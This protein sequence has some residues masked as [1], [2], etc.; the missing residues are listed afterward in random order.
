MSGWR[1]SPCSERGRRGAG[2]PGLTFTDQEVKGQEEQHSDE[3]A[4]EALAEPV[5]AHVGDAW[6]HAEKQ[7]EKRATG[8]LGK[9]PRSP[10]DQGPK[11]SGQTCSV[12]SRPHMSLCVATQ[13]PPGHSSEKASLA[14][15]TQ[16]VLI[17][18]IFFPTLEESSTF[19]II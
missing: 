8:C 7:V 12:V 18:A 16:T 3:A 19:P 1:C 5:A 14:Q 2:G 4:H 13:T 15:K 6:R 17:T 10:P 11:D 9:E